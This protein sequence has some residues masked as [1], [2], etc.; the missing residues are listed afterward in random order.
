MKE[1]DYEYWEDNIGVSRMIEKLDEIKQLEERYKFL[2]GE[3]NVLKQKQC[4]MMVEKLKISKRL[5]ELQNGNQKS[6]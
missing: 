1:H 3:I 4:E 2:V 5:K 6:N